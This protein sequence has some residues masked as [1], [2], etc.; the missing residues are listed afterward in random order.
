MQEKHSERFK[1]YGKIHHQR[2]SLSRTL[3]RVCSMKRVFVKIRY[4]HDIKKRRSKVFF[5]RFRIYFQT[6]NRKRF[7][8]VLTLNNFST[9]IKVTLRILRGFQYVFRILLLSSPDFPMSVFF[10]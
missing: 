8:N 7:E 9:I 3:P 2:K 6:I 1:I 4:E 10:I 5:K